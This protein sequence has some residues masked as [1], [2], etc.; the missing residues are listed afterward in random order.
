M[1]GFSIGVQSSRPEAVNAVS[2]IAA[3]EEWA[4]V[5]VV[6]AYATLPGVN[7][8]VGELEQFGWWQTSRKRF[9]VGLDFG[10]TEPRA[11]RALAAL[12]NATATVHQASVVLAA[13]LRPPTLF[14]PKLY[15]FSTTEGF[16]RV[17]IQ[18][19]IVG[20]VNLTASALTTNIEAFARFRV[21][22]ST[23]GDKGVRFELAIAERLAR[24]GTPPTAA[25]LEDYARLRPAPGRRSPPT[26]EAAPGAGHPT[27]D[28]GANE[29]RAL[30]GARYF[31]SDTGNVYK[32]RGPERPGNQLDLR[33]GARVFWGFPA[34]RE[35][36]KAAVLGTFTVL[37]DR[38]D[39]D[40][41]IRFGGK[42]GMDKINLPVDD[43]DYSDGRLLWE[44]L[45]GVRRFRLKW[46][47]D[48]AAWRRA[49][50]NEGKL[51]GY[52]RNEREWGYF[53][54]LE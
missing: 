5:L 41:N 7:Q 21:D 18:S 52:M 23:Q 30:R 3:E 35:E 45:P 47:R 20:S 32:N 27:A 31:W 37:W 33:K 26:E 54:V 2:E 1:S 6:V 42:Q 17:G 12:P 48:G 44:R 9:L 8:L 38:R 34:P 24:A 28:M 53:D 15:A 29:L 25:M 10:H 50:V 39:V 16:G 43:D 4:G 40:C 36:A 13:N 51:R 49:S 46:D 19:G 22:G 14:H 11:I